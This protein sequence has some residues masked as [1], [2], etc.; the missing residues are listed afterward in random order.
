MNTLIFVSMAV[1][2]CNLQ[3]ALISSNYQPDQPLRCEY[4]KELI[5]KADQLSRMEEKK[6]LLGPISREP[7]V[8][9]ISRGE[10]Q[11]GCIVTLSNGDM[12]FSGKPCRR[13][14]GEK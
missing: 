4:D 6:Y 14:V 8:G 11:V 1:M 9:P 2:K 13:L 3:M 7:Q 5:V 12:L 10:P